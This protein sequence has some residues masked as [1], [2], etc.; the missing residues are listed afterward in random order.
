MAEYC[1]E[2][3]IMICSKKYVLS[4]MLLNLIKG[5]NISMMLSVLSSRNIDVIYYT[6]ELR[7]IYKYYIFNISPSKNN[8]D[9]FGV[10]LLLVLTRH[11]M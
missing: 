4:D 2:C 11:I 7:E 8:Q 1:S 6:R 3:D 5:I 9:S 10:E